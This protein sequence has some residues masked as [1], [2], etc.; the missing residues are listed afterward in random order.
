M[1]PSICLADFVM[2]LGQSF[3]AP[4][5]VVKFMRR[6][7]VELRAKDVQNIYDANGYSSALELVTRVEKKRDKL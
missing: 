7:G 6:R 5:N 2:D 1:A 3:M 4:R